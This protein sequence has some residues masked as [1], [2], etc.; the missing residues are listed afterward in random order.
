MR[1]HLRG[2]RVSPDQKTFAVHLDRCLHFN[3]APRSHNPGST[4]RRRTRARSARHPDFLQPGCRRR[5]HTTG[6][7]GDAWWAG[8]GRDRCARPETGSIGGRQGEEVRFAADSPLGGDGFEPSVPHK[9]Q[10]FLAAPVRSRNSPS[11]TKTGSFVPGTDGSNPS[12]SSKESANFRSL[13]EPGVFESH[14]RV[15]PHRRAHI[16]E[17]VLYRIP[18]SDAARTRARGVI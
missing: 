1:H 16:C 14:F 3:Y 5:P 9:K 18:L 2:H 11:P 7:R 17:N 13:S 15:R 10:P 8:Y 6:G 4:S 12:P